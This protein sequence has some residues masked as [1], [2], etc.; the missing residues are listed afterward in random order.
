MLDQK[1]KSRFHLD[2]GGTIEL[3]VV[4]TLVLPV[5][6]D[7]FFQGSK[8]A[9]LS[10]IALVLLV[11]FS[12]LSNHKIFLKNA[13]VGQDTIVVMVA[14]Y[15]LGTALSLS[16]G[17]VLTPLFL[18]L[19]TLSIILALNIDCYK[20]A[21][22]GVGLSAHILSFASVAAIF[23][24]L[25]P[26][27]FYFN[28]AEYPVF[29][30]QI[31]IA[32]RN[33]GVFVHPNV[34]GEVAALSIVFILGSKSNKFLLFAPVF[35]LMKCG[36][37]N[38]IFGIIAATLF[39][40]LSKFV[41]RDNFRKIGKI[42]FPWILRI[43]IALA[44]L[45]TVY[46]II[47]SINSLDP[48]LFTGRAGVWQSTLTLARHSPILGLGWDFESRAISSNLLNAWSVSAHNNFLEIAFCTGFVGL[49]LFLV[50]Y[51][52][53]ILNFSRLLTLEKML[54]IYIFISGLVEYT[55]KFTYPSVTSYLFIF[56]NIGASL[57]S[58]EK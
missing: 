25:N 42:E 35:C 8:I 29:F 24:R 40:V 6:L 13:L 50:L 1:P 28:D 16:H 21:L 26:T 52:K 30:K 57:R 53:V 27:N 43:L 18:S 34:L 3:F 49:F 31:G 45:A 55:I 48:A 51:S 38:A 15:V 2:R 11:A 44:S 12:V 33:I 14:L 10:R 22:N 23:L 7:L 4:L 17:G 32:G 58:K 37:R 54:V 5:L 47:Q 41:K 39:L 56:I 36:S 46:K 19:L 20:F 9:R